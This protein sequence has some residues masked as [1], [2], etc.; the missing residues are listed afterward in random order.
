MS[1]LTAKS[2]YIRHEPT[3]F[4]K[5][6]LIEGEGV[7]HLLSDKDFQLNWDLLHSSCPWSTVFQ[8]RE[9][10]T[11]WYGIYKSKFIPILLKSEDNGKLT[12]LLALAL[13][14]ENIRQATRRP[15]VSCIVGAGDNQAEYQVWLSDKMDGGAFIQEALSK[16]LYRYKGYKIQLRYV[17]GQTPLEWASI[18]QFW[19]KRCFLRQVRQPLIT[20]EEG[21]INAELRKKNRKEKINRL[22]RLGDLKFE[23][24]TDRQIFLSIFD[25]L[26]LQ[27]DFRK[28]AMFNTS[29]FQTDS[30]RKDFL[31]AL[32]DQNLLHTTILTLNGEIIA[33]NVG[34][35]D[36]NWVH[37]QGI[38][39]HAPTFA[40]YSPGILHFLML[41]RL[42]WEEG[43]QAFD[44][45]PGADAYKDA[46]AT[47]YSSAFHVEIGSKYSTSLKYAKLF[48]IDAVKR[49]GAKTGIQINNFNYLKNKGLF[50]AKKITKGV[51]LDGAV[52]L[53]GVKRDDNHTELSNNGFDKGTLP[54]QMK[55]SQ[56]SLSDLLAYDQIGSARTRWEFLEEAM[57][58][59]ERGDRS[60]TWSESGRLLACVWLRAPRRPATGET[61]SIPEEP[62]LEGIYC[63]RSVTDRLDAFIKN[64]VSQ[65]AG[66]LV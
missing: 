33:S 22:K 64:V 4:G 29:F 10:V 63:H 5:V 51:L 66:E 52:S 28:E 60:Y 20:F 57:R 24:I 44:L 53:S 9:F 48:L 34:V 45:T 32:F 56:C 6:E 27:Y 13:P 7:F 15:P 17:P 65:I 30:L 23:R 47:E 3:T 43:K 50:L 49:L 54:S 62:N 31:L 21:R 42:L 12:G 61:Q 59:L 37:L 41:S 11:T 19:S 8:S 36:G 14:R 2:K 1:V 16:L 26:A 40:K 46:L 55:I 25:G 39:T 38:N 18:D 58:R 35:T